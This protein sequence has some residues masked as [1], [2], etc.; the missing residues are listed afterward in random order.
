MLDTSFF[1]IF[2]FV[3]AEPPARYNT[4]VPQPQPPRH[5]HST[6]PRTYAFIAPHAV[7]IE[8][9]L[10]VASSRA[11]PTVLTTSAV[12]TFGCVNNAER[13]KTGR[14][15]SYAAAV[16]SYIPPSKDGQTSIFQ[17]GGE[18]KLH[19]VITISISWI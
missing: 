11:N 7:R 16:V 8:P 13:D 5:D 1:P 19:F 9:R 10:R 12:R 4:Q 14:G 6:S 3:T 18:E 17:A 2:S 15:G